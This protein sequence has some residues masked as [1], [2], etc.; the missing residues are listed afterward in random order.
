L[1]PGRHD[2]SL[3]VIDLAGNSSEQ[4]FE[5]VVDVEAPQVQVSVD[6]D[7]NGGVVVAVSATDN[8][9][10]GRVVITAND[11]PLGELLGAGTMRIDS[12]DLAAGPI[13]I[14]ATAYDLVGIAASAVPVRV[15]VP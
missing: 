12:R 8:I 1:S 13:D 3:I 2:A 5:L 15:V 14:G 10:M 6:A 4:S 9:G 7:D 11:A